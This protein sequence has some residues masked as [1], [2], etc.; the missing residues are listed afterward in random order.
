MMLSDRCRKIKPSA[1]LTIAEKAQELRKQG[2][3][4]L[5]LN[6][7]EPDFDTPLHIKAA[8]MDGIQEGKT[9]YTPTAGTKQL[10][11]AIQEKLMREN[12]LRYDLT[13]ISAC[14]GGKQAIYNALMAL[15]NKGDEVINQAP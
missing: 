14:N 8:A 7:G 11:Q 4:I 2:I 10:R 5:S 13:E 3:D 1:T 15:I 9:K 12:N 6:A